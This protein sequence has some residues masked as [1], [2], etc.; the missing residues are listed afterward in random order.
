VNQWT[1]LVGTLALVY[2]IASG[3]PSTLPLDERQAMELFLTSAQSLFALVLIVALALD[4]KGALALFVLFV[5]QL[6][7]PWEGAHLWFAIAYVV[8]AIAILVVDDTRRKALLRL[9]SEARLA[10]SGHPAAAEPAPAPQAESVTR[11][12]VPSPR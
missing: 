6:V 10:L 2:S 4:W 3:R 5:A 9:L 12:P 11:Q 8:L 7:A 1:L